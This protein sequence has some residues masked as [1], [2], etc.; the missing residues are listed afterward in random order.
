MKAIQIRFDEIDEIDERYEEFYELE[1]EHVIQDSARMG[2]DLILTSGPFYEVVDK[3]LVF[4]E[5]TYFA[6]Y[7][8]DLQPDWCLTLLYDKVPESEEEL[9]SYLYFEQGSPYSAI[10]NYLTAIGRW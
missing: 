10:R 2:E 5:G 7:D 4:I 6:L 8:G 1:E 3:G 9:L